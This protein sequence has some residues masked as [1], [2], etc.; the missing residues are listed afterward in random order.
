MR[1]STSH[2]EGERIRR[3]RH[4]QHL[5]AE[6]G[7]RHPPPPQ[8]TVP[9]PRLLTSFDVVLFAFVLLSGLALVFC[10]GNAAR[11]GI[12]TQAYASA[13][14]DL[15][16]MHV[17]EAT[18]TGGP[19][20]QDWTAGPTGWRRGLRLCRLDLQSQGTDHLASL[21]PAVCGSSPVARPSRPDSGMGT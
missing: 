5:P 2:H 4:H 19:A 10:A 6:P 14:P 8:H 12:E 16:L 1:R 9:R 3:W 17:S 11:A 15:R 21:D 13:T 18:V 20:I 7:H